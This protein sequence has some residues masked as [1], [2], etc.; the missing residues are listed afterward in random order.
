MRACLRASSPPTLA[1]SVRARR[2][3]GWRRPASI[4]RRRCPLRSSRQTWPGVRRWKTLSSLPTTLDHFQRWSSRC[5][6]CSCPF[7]VQRRV[8][9]SSAE[10]PPLCSRGTL[11]WK[12][13]WSCPTLWRVLKASRRRQAFRTGVS[14]PRSWTVPNSP[15]SRASSRLCPKAR[16]GATCR[17]R[18]ARWSLSGP[19]NCS[20]E[21]LYMS[22]EMA[23]APMATAIA[24]ARSST[25]MSMPDADDGDSCTVPCTKA[26]WA[27]SSLRTSSGSF[28][29]VDMCT[30]VELRPRW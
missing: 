22:P 20:E 1:C 21:T 30:T 5:R 8:T 2:W 18:Q 11:S 16:C 10:P 15:S 12:T 24:R 14:S 27:T 19:R 13:I 23:P 28:R 17:C 6:T 26:T 7:E 25:Q 3:S 4:C 29:S 9:A